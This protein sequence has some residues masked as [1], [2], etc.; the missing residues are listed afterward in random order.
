MDLS[1]MFFGADTPADTTAGTPPRHSEA[2]DDILA[3][4][5]DRG[6]AR[7]PRHLDARAAL[8]AGGAGV[9][10][11][12]GAQRGA[13]RGDR[14]DQH[15][16]GQRDPAAAPSAADRGGLGRR[17]QPLARPD[18]AVRGDRLA[19]RRLRP[20]PRQLR[21]PPRADP[22]G[23]SAAAS[24]VGGR[25]GRVH[26]RHRR[27]GRRPAAAPARAGHPPAVAHQLR[28]PGDLGGR[29]KS[30]HRGPRGDR[31]AEPGGAGREDRP[32]SRRLRR[33][34][35]PGRH[36]RAR[37]GDADDAHVRRRGRRARRGA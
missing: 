10:Q 1:V 36:R 13:R 2:Y 31:R 23:H 18:R 22:A 32:L 34:P 6:P 30:A 21:R 35:R 15:P 19:L 9:P 24:A 5:R 27:L 14:A 20:G 3:V 26:R 12:A 17:R 33:C 4:A 16:G 28:Q 37:P 11:S 8:P 29:R 25:A 7:L